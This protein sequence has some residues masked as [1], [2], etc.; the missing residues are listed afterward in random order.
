MSFFGEPELAFLEAQCWSLLGDGRRA[1]RHARH[2]AA[3]A[4][5]EFARNRALYRAQL[6]ADLARD[7]APEEAAEVGGR[8]L[9]A[10]GEVQSTRI[11]AMLAE[12]ARAL[13]PWRTAPQ[14]AAFLARRTGAGAGAASRTRPPAAAPWT[15]GPTRA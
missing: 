14:V 7:G 5:P 1:V 13:E 15:T 12:T 10:L 9:D 4:G 6:A 2:A 11:R 8:V 3:L